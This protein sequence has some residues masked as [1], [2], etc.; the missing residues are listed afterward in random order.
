[1]SDHEENVWVERAEAAWPWIMLGVGLIYK[2]MMVVEQASQNYE[3]ESND[4]GW[5]D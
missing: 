2:L 5:E 3:R 1:M 4:A